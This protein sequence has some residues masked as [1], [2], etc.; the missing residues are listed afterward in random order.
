MI[1]RADALDVMTLI[2]A[3][4]RRTAPRM[5]DREVTL[6]TADVWARLF[7]AY[8]LKLPDLLEAVEKRARTN[9]DAPEPAEIITFA[10]DIRR[11]RGE[12]MS[13]E[14]RQALEDRRDAE[15]EARNRERLNEIIDGI[16][17]RKTID[18]EPDDPG[19]P[20]A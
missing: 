17:E 20:D 3:C 15:L 12:R 4:H 2:Q 6:A 11:D 18:Q 14:E 8:R 16:A 7:N 5:D 10:R 1:T 19:E 13:T 9:A